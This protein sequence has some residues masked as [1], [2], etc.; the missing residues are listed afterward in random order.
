MRKGRSVVACA[1]MLCLGL[2]GAPA[3][4]ADTAAHVRLYTYFVASPSNP[5]EAKGGCGALV[6]TEYM[7]PG[8]TAKNV[9]RTCT[10]PANTPVLA[11][12][13]GCVD[14]FPVG[15]KTDADVLEARDKDC[16]K[17]KKPS[18]V[19]DGK[20]I[21]VAQTYVK[22]GAYTV[23]VM[24]GSLIRTVDGTFPADAVEARVASAGWTVSFNSLKKGKHTLALSDLVDKK[25]MSI[26]FSLTVE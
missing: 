14:W 26:T 12:P 24:Q 23:P 15:S 5:L 4:A 16:S 1:A 6:G 22:S 3:E 19:L 20:K 7:L 8:A 2:F 25:V 11:S 18:V 21:A 9:K 10:I 17:V 13:G